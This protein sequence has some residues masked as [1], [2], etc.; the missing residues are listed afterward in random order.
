MWRCRSTGSSRGG[1]RLDGLG[2]LLDQ[3]VGTT[4]GGQRRDAGPDHQPRLDD[5]AD[6]GHVDR[7]AAHQERW[8]QVEAGVPAV[9]ADRGGAAVP[10]L[11]Q[12][13]LGH[14]LQRLADGRPRDAQHLGEPALAGQRWPG[15]E[16]AGDHLVEDLVEDLVGDRAAEDGLEG[17]GP[18]R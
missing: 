15:A 10:D 12:P 11:E 9:V 3:R 2:E 5:A 14:P 16:G 1:V 7:P 4:G 13:G 17:H 8:E 6:G 18:G